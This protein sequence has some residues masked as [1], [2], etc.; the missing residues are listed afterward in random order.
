MISKESFGKRTSHQFLVL[1]TLTE[2]TKVPSADISPPYS[3]LPLII[4]VLIV[5]AAQTL[6]REVISR[7]VRHTSPPMR[8]STQRRAIIAVIESREIILVLNVEH[9]FLALPLLSLSGISLQHD[10][11]NRHIR[12]LRTETTITEG[13][14]MS[15]RLMLR[16]KGLSTLPVSQDYPSKETLTCSRPACLLALGRPVTPLRFLPPTSCLTCK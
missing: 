9:A 6:R 10:I 14:G 11:L 7:Q 5:V 15:P 8:Q 4:V 1:A 13:S 12:V 16:Q 3:A 2:S